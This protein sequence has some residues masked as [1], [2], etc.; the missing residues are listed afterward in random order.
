M[1]LVYTMTK[2]VLSVLIF[3][4]FLALV[5]AS[6]AIGIVTSPGEFRL[7]GSLIRGNSS[8]FEGNVLETKAARSV[9]QLGAT[10]ITLLPESRAKVFH[11]RTVMEKGSSLVAGASYTLEADTLRITPLAKDTLL[12]VEIAAPHRVLV[13]AQGGTAEVHNA[14]GVLVASLHAGMALTFDPQAGASTAVKM[15][16]DVTLQD[17]KFYLTDWCANVKVEL[18]GTDLAQ[19]LGKLVDMSGSG[20]PGA[21]ASG[22]ASQ[23][24]QVV[25]ITAVTDKKRLAAPCGAGAAGAAGA[26][27]LSAAATGAIIGGV[28]VAGVLVGLAAAGT[29]SSGAPS[30]PH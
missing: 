14:S 1:R 21:T 19:Y 12:Q 25:T 4:C 29:F 26:G 17:G 13:A 7:D 2:I 23:V 8:L 30:S 18:R 24:V 28:A 10:R 20:I 16:G 27:G 11:D 5:A 15:T 6:P 3:G 22:G 9:A